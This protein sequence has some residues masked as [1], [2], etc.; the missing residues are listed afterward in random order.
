ML[1]RKLFKR[2][3]ETKEDVKDLIEGLLS[4]HIFEKSA[5]PGRIPTDFSGHS[6]YH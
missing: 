6:E 3:Y 1:Q 4:L 2:R 5:N